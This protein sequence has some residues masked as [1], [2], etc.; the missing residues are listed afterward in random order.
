MWGAGLGL[1]GRAVARRALVAVGLLALSGGG[2]RL[3]AQNV[4]SVPFTNGFVGTRGSSAGTANNVLTYAT[5]GIDRAFFIQNSSTTQFQLQ[6]GLQ[7]NDIYGTL[8]LVRTS[9]ATIDI[10][11]V[12]NWRQNDGNYTYLIGILPR[13]TSPVTLTYGSGQTLQITTGDDP[14]GTSIGGYVAGYTGAREA[15]GA[16]TNGNAAQSQVLGGLNDY[17]ASVVSSRPAGP[18][19]VASL[20]T[21]STT[22]TLTGTATVA[23]NEALSVVVAGAQ[24]TAT[25]SP[26]VA[27]SGTSWS[28]ALA[29]P[30]A[31]GTYDVA[32]TITDADGF[33]LS[34]ATRNEL[35]VSAA[36]HT[37]TLGGAFTATSK[38]YDG[39]TAATGATGGL[40][41]AGVQPGDQVTISGVTLAFQTAAAA[42]GKT[43]TVTGVT[44]GG[45]QAGQYAV[46]LAGAPTAAA[47]VTPA[48]LT[49]TGVTAASKT[50]DGTT[51]AT[52]AGTAAYQGLAAGESF[53]V[54]G[55]PAAAFATS[56]AGA[57]RAVTV[58]GYAP[59]SGN[60]SVAQP[61]GLTAT[62]APKALTLA[63]TFTVA[64]RAFDGTTAA[65]LATNTLTLA[66]VVGADAVTLGPVTA[67][68]AT[69]TAGTGKTVTLTAA[70]LAG[71]DAGNYTVSLAGAPTATASITAAPVAT[72]TV[73]LAG[74]LAADDKVYDGTTAA[75]GSAAGLTLVGVLP[76]DQ[77]T[78]AAVTLA[79]QTA[80]RAPASRWPSPPSRSAAPTPRATRRASPGRPLRRR[81]SPPRLPRRPRWPSPPRPAT[82][83][84]PSRGRPPPPPA[85]RPSP[86]TWPTSAPT[87]ARRGRA[88]R[89]RTRR[90]RS[91]PASRTTSRTPCA[92]PP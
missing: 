82:A 35:T 3:A 27:R 55:T 63:G 36:A 12:A 76:G 23:A 2:R 75:T 16:S 5:L 56:A 54:A 11:A 86:A 18:V 89:W 29:A 38:V 50:Y 33:T 30:L 19:T 79:F 58:S 47:D 91:S 66:G 21:T 73:T 20:A 42:T 57:G 85:A 43:V 8:R 51:T 70:P 80:A 49:V 81:A 72:T 22:P 48:L 92:W 45:A 4:I 31:A 61:A 41:L 68:F 32:A 13:P 37:V 84:S 15:D 14:G 9:G 40:T 78:I 83:R 88:P 71:A 44:L 87:A 26:A 77:V 74:Q 90:P 67:A 39:T 65:P 1:V 64:D 60:Y 53:A 52:L 25:T 46:S 69:P 62:I 59:P 10:P 34:D 28:L 7:G 24:Y 17:L 6:S